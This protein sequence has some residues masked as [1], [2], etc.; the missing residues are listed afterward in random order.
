MRQNSFADTLTHLLALRGE[1]PLLHADETFRAS[2]NAQRGALQSF[3]AAG[4]DAYRGK[5]E[6]CSREIRDALQAQPPPIALVRRR[7]SVAPEPR[8]GW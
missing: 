1:P 5:R 4:L 6:A 8:R 2:L 7:R 3:Y